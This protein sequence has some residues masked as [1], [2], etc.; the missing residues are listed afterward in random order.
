[1]FRLHQPSRGGFTLIELLVVIAIIAILIAL[2]VP[3]VQKVRAAAARTQ[4]INNLRQIGLATHTLNDANKAL[5]PLVAPD[6]LSALTVN[7]RYPHAIGFTVFDWLLP[8]VDQQPLFA[9]I[10]NNV[11]TV[12]NGGPAYA[13]IVPV[14]R[15][16]SDPSSP[17]GKGATT[18]GS[19]NTWAIGNYA[20]NYL[21]FGNPSAATV[22]ARLEGTSKISTTFVDG[23]SNTIMYAERYGTCGSSGAVNGPTTYGNLWSNS[24]SVWR[25]VIC[26]NNS[27]QSPAA[28]GYSPCNLFQITPDWLRGCKTTSAQSPHSAGI[29]VCFGDASVR[30]A[31]P[32]LSATVWAQACDPQDGQ[33]PVID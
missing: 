25:P 18:N 6:C 4:C 28:A 16:P 33:T 7:Q 30:T 5:P 20:A 29:P 21:V 1:M 2:L 10:N 9:A 12:I 11:T 31:S 17:S 13:Q 27:A 14:Y 3:A 24:N 23:T 22:A 26:I 8:Y 15:C 19:A 32:S